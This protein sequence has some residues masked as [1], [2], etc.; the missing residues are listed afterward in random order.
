MNF[1]RISMSMLLIVILSNVTLADQGYDK[2]KDG[3][4]GT[5]SEPDCDNESVPEYL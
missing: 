2:Q 1:L 5:V 4:H 3:T